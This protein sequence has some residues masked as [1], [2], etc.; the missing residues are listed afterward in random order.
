MSPSIIGTTNGKVASNRLPLSTHTLRNIIN[1]NQ[2]FQPPNIHKKQKILKTQDN[3]SNTVINLTNLR[4]SNN[5]DTASKTNDLD[6]TSITSTSITSTDT[7]HTLDQFQQSDLQIF[8]R[9]GGDTLLR[10]PNPS[11]IPP[12]ASPSKI[13]IESQDMSLHPFQSLVRINYLDTIVQYCQGPHTTVILRVYHKPHIHLTTKDLRDIISHNSP[14]NHE[15]LVLGLEVICTNY[16][17][18]Y[19][20]PSFM[21]TLCTQGW[22]SVANRF[23]PSESNRVD[24]P[25]TTSSII[26]IPIHVNGNHWVA[27]CC[28]IISGI[29]HFYYAD[30]MKHPSTEATI[31]RYITW[32]TSPEFSPPTS[33]WISCQTPQFSPHSNECGPR[34]LLALAIMICHPSPHTVT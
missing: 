27:L 16:N 23:H 32:H 13:D 21:P 5:K 2:S 4:T 22:S 10:Q 12:W 28:R 24:R 26:A 17:S 1:V 31:K 30:D 29:V 8:R 25:S 18:S 20:D 15:T 34:T 9:I 33:R 19:L 7:D 6:N 11:Q 3:A 14:I